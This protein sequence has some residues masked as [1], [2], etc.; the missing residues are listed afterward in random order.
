LL[1]QQGLS[2]AEI[3]A[4]LDLTALEVQNDLGIAAAITQPVQNRATATV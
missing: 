2:V 4:Q 1:E 3:A